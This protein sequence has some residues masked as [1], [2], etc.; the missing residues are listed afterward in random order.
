MPMP[1]LSPA[2]ATKAGRRPRE[3]CNCPLGWRQARAEAQVEVQTDKPKY[4]RP[5]L[6][7]RLNMK[8]Q[9]S[10][11]DV[12]TWLRLL[13]AS[14]ANLLQA[15]RACRICYCCLLLSCKSKVGI[16]TGFKSRG[17]CAQAKLPVRLMACCCSAAAGYCRASWD[18]VV[19][20]PYGSIMYIFIDMMVLLV[21]GCRMPDR[22]YASRSST[23]QNHPPFTMSKPNYQAKIDHS[24][25]VVFH[26]EEKLGDNRKK[27]EEEQQQQ[28]QGPLELDTQM[29]RLKI[30]E[31]SEAEAE[32]SFLD[33][34]IKLA[35]AE[36]EALKAAIAIAEEDNSCAMKCY[37]GYVPGEDH[38]IIDDFGKIFLSGLI[39]LG[40]DVDLGECLIAAS[41]ATADK[42]PEAWEDP[43]KIKLVVSLFA[44]NGTQHLLEE[45]DIR[46]ARFCASSAF[47]LQARSACLTSDIVRSSDGALPLG[48]VTTILNCSMPTSTPLSST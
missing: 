19:Q 44:S 40:G 12:P 11:E 46:S 20:I 9:Y 41:R 36:K 24:Q 13:L 32:A 48:M 42:Y 27:K 2:T 34:A 18:A 25:E 4:D 10:A 43:S 14:I 33:E 8:V 28:Q 29:E 1:T 39:S 3:E 16:N 35:A 21:A 6:S 15:W 17:V 37:H 23:L 30:V 26:D 47:F 45:E 7:G 31:D 38:F 5:T 22:S